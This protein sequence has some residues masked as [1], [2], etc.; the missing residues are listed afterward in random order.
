MDTKVC[1]Q[2]IRGVITADKFGEVRF[3]NFHSIGKVFEESKEE[4]AADH[5]RTEAGKLIFGHQE[6]ITHLKF[7]PSKTLILTVDN[8]RKI[9]LTHFP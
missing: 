5:E 7:N 2:L 3:F 1:G 4:T 8:A 9:K 6:I